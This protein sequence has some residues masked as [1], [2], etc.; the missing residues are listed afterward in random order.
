MNNN[1]LLDIDFLRQLDQNENKEIYGKI[2]LLTQDELPVYEIQGKITNGSINVDGASAI[3]R[4]CS[5]T[6]VANEVDIN[7]SY[8]ALKNKFKLE[9]GVRNTINSN[10]PE[11]IWFKQGIYVFTSLNMNVQL[12]NFT[13]NLSGKDKMCLL[14]GESGG[15]IN[16]S[17]DF[18]KLEEYE[19]IYTLVEIT[20]KDYIKDYY[21]YIDNNKYVLDS[22]ENFSEKREY[23]TMEI[24]KNDIE[25][26]IV[27]II[28]NAVHVY[29][30]EALHNIVLNDIENYGLE[31]LEYRGD[32][33]LYMPRKINSGEVSNLVINEKQIYYLADGKGYQVDDT[34][35][36]VYYDRT[37]KNN[38]SATKVWVV[39]NDVGKADEA[40]NIIKIKFG[41][42]AGYR[43]TNLTYPGDLIAN[44]GESLVTI[45]DKI[46]N[47]F[48]DFEYFYD[49]DGRFIFQKKKTYL[50]NSWNPIYTDQNQ[51]Y[52]ENGNYS[53]SYAYTFENGILLT[54]FSNNPNI[55]NIKND[56]SIWG[57]RKGASG[58]E[59][60]IHMRYA[61]DEKPIYYKPIRFKYREKDINSTSYYPN[62]YYILDEKNNYILSIGEFQ[63]NVK[64]YEL[65]DI[66]DLEIKPFVSI[67]YY[68]EVVITK[69]EFDS[70]EYCGTLA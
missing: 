49:L 11:T 29:G 28:K 59:L 52:V 8:W 67:D 19:N 14:N 44:I 43:K 48:S 32:K 51:I 65:T 35:N 57:K 12:A 31:L 24:I 36:I 30:G 37:G 5:L 53:S 62:K 33:D 27:D 64:Y 61:I 6:M 34:E 22:S 55:T 1:Y 58:T 4:T 7:N 39:A 45:L 2:I 69:Q 16:A 9:V 10:Y 70:G 21:Y 46:K 66:Q 15:T 25:M 63:E 42:T 40:Y 26:P 50:N 13:I 20:E 54:N 60:P 23:Y 41:E 38:E 17:T 68:M 56:F 47:M 3:R 18:G